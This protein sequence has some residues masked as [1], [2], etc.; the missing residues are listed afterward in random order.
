[1]AWYFKASDTVNWKLTCFIGLKVM[2][3]VAALL[4]VKAPLSYAVREEHW[5]QILH[6][7]LSSNSKW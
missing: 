5:K 6:I 3:V 7:E 1:M 2:E 4:H